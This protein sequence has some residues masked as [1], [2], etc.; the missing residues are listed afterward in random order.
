ML[1]LK[2]WNVNVQAE[3]NLELKQDLKHLQFEPFE[4]FLKGGLILNIKSIKSIKAQNYRS[5]LNLI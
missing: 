4:S 1:L 5:S 3:I 2:C